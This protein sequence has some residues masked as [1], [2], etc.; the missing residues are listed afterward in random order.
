MA[1]HLLDKSCA[2]QPTQDI[3]ESPSTSSVI[4]PQFADDS[5]Q[6]TGQSTSNSQAA[7]AVSDGPNPDQNSEH[8][9]NNPATSFTLE[10]YAPANRG[11]RGRGRGNR[12]RAWQRAPD[13]LNPISI[14][15]EIQNFRKFFVVSDLRGEN[16][17]NKI[18]TITANRQLEAQLHG[19]PDKVTEMRNGSL[20]IKVKNVEQSN[21]IKLLRGLDGT[22]VAI[23]EH[24]SLN[25]TKGTI[26]S[27]RYVDVAD[28]RLMEQLRTQDVT[29]IYRMK[30]KINNEFVHT[31]TI[32]LT[33][34]RYTLPDTV[35]IGWNVFEVRE[36]IPLPRRCF[37]C[38]GYNH[39]RLA[40]HAIQI[41]C[42]NCGNTGHEETGCTRSTKCVNCEGDHKASS[43]AC[44]Q[45]QF[46]KEV[47]AVQT[48]QKIGYGE[49]KRNVLKRY[50]RP[51]DISQT[52][53][54][55]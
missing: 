41:V 51:G 32:V 29:E 31:G 53:P 37:K 21:N 23:T 6:S 26:R 40:C 11:R 39:S 50:V 25:F 1:V 52:Q 43:H 45:Y 16:L 44:P 7:A 13:F 28:D 46:E 8:A 2:L 10:P 19:A 49:A 15:Q 42:G 5:E 27:R 48:R 33:F 34:D 38:Q 12:Q 22:D 9:P 17:I 3:L 4:S 36:Y 54:T 18:D 24:G 55:R 14:Q 35:K 47:L 20:L 30:K